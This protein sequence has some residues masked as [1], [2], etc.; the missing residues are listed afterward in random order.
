M[1]QILKCLAEID[2][3]SSNNTRIISQEASTK[4][5]SKLGLYGDILSAIQDE[6]SNGKVKLTRVQFR[7]NTS[8]D[9]L[10]RYLNEL[11]KKNLIEKNPLKITNK[12][13]K[14]LR[15]Y[16]KIR[17]DIERISQDFL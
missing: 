5:R 17:D 10:I 4:R 3:F 15:E 6:A 14:F 8:Y 12:G 1:R 9:K 7:S 2:R 16:S 13:W 11:E